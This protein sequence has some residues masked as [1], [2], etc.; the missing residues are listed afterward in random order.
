VQSIAGMVGPASATHLSG[1]NY[2]NWD[3]QEP[4]WRVLTHLNP[5]ANDLAAFAK[6]VIHLIDGRGI[7]ARRYDHA[8]GRKTE[9]APIKPAQFV[10]ASGLHALWS[11]ALTRR[12]DLRIYLD[13]EEQLRRRLK[14]R[15]DTTQRGHDLVEV[16]ETIERRAPDADRYIRPQAQTAD[17]VF[18]LEA[19]HPSLLDDNTLGEALPLRLI[20]RVRPGES[21]TAVSRLLTSL[22][23]MKVVE[24]TDESGWRRR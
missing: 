17:L 23:G 9:P 1:D 14:I 24:H 16:L 21:L 10:L 6:D 19:R 11:P 7:H 8:T 20:V 2:H 22:C 4:M 15:R 3:R 18:R 5:H 13:M 12:Y